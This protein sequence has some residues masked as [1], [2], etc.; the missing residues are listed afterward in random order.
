VDDFGTGYPSLSYLKCFPVYRL[1][2]DEL[3]VG[4]IGTGPD[5]GTAIALVVIAL[6]HNLKLKVIAEGVETAAQLAFLRQARC[7][8]AQGYYFF[9][10]L[11]HPELLAVLT[12]LAAEVPAGS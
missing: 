7:D 3:F 5:H 10:P 4:D 11:P 9:K 8:E 6:G 12:G 2:I 1:K